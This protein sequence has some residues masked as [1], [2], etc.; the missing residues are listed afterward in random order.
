M[1]HAG[2]IRWWRHTASALSGNISSAVGRRRSRDPAGLCAERDRARCARAIGRKGVSMNPGT[3]KYERLLQRCAGL[4]P[5]PTAVAHPCEKS[6]LAGAIEAAEL[7]LIK[8]IL[9]G[10]AAR[11][12]EIAESAAIDLGTTEIV[13]TAHSNASAAKALELVRQ[14]RAELLMKGSLHSDEVLAAVVARETG[15]RTGRRISH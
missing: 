9:V 7:G 2:G 1:D 13:D 4:Q 11:I 15:L 14:G 12:R 6:A 5:V 8:P 3:G 10:P